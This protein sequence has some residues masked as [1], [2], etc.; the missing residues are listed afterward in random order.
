MQTNM[1]SMPRS[2]SR[3]RILVECAMMIAIGTVLASIK[4]FTMPNGGSITLVSMLPFILVSYRHGVRWGM[5]TG[6]V[7]SILQM[8]VG[9]WAPPAG[10]LAAFA[11]MILL[12]YVLA[13]TLLG[14]A[15]IFAKPFGGPRKMLGAAV[16]TAAVCS[17]R[18]VCSFLSGF[19]I[20]GSLA[21]DG[22]GAVIYSL[23]YNLSYMLPETI[24]TVVTAALLC[25]AAPQL[26]TAD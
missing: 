14:T 2:M 9:W 25:R 16:G 10:T 6:L 21:A 7:N 1:R 5:F 17:I 11:G 18:F 12:D 26:F 15:V 19:L 8:M 4:V 20:W 3:V 13:F 22:I 24:I 23:Q